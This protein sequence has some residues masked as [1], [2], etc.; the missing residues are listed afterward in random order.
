VLRRTDQLLVQLNRAN[1]TRLAR[2]NFSLYSNLRSWTD[3]L[4]SCS[5]RECVRR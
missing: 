3:W 4:T 5:L 2:R 1:G